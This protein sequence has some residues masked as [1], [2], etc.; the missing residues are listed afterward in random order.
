LTVSAE[1]PFAEVA[2]EEG[3]STW[4]CAAAGAVPAVVARPADAGQVAEVV[5]AVGDRGQA[6]IAVGKGARLGIGNRPRAYDVA[7]STAALSAVERHVAEDMTVTVQAGM[8]LAALNEA[9]GARR[10]WLPFD[11]SV[12]EETT[13]G[14][15]IAA[16]ANGPLRH[17]YGKVRDSLLGVELVNGRGEVVRGGG[18]VVKNVAGYDLPRLMCGSFGTL[19]VIV[20]ATFKTQPK[21]PELSLWLWRFDSLPEAVRQARELDRGGI[22]ASFVEALSEGAC[23]AIGVDGSAALA[24]GF[25]GSAAEVRG[26]SERLRSAS[27]G[28]A[29][30]VERSKASG[31]LK[32]IRNFAEP[33]SEDA[34]VGRLAVSPSDLPALL[35]RIESEAGVRGVALDVSAHAA[36]GVARCQILGAGDNARSALFAEWLRLAV[37]ERGGWVTYEAMPGEL[38]GRLD[39]WGMSGPAVQLMRGVKRVFDPDGVLAPGRFVG[40]I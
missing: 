12:A 9:L 37:R 24:M 27:Q 26:E 22:A 35:G 14:G 5:R 40:G 8:T 17:T 31:V 19:G 13:V 10:Q 1:R 16:D 39:T 29:N 11:P 15:L 38:R 28:R 34:V 21:P 23:E 2:S 30:E 18:K 3:D 33:L 6:L 32:A 25:A 7:L 36:I 20:S 4:R